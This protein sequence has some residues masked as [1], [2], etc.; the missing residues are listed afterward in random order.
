VT[1]TSAIEIRA[2]EAPI[3]PEDTSALFRGSDIPF[4]SSLYSLPIPQ[5]ALFFEVSS[6]YVDFCLF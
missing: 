2:L 3:A 5:P 1:Y 4:L 6:A